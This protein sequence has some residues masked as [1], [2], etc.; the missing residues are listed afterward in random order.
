MI[1]VNFIHRKM[2]FNL[3]IYKTK[4]TAC[5]FRHC[6]FV[7]K[8]HSDEIKIHT[9]HCDEVAMYIVLFESFGDLAFARL[10]NV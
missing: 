3:I 2:S 8:V 5:I 7:E 6:D 1:S 4:K 9:K 10:K